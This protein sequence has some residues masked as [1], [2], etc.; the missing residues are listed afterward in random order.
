MNNLK[1]TPE[2]KEWLVALKTKIRSAQIKASLAVN[3]ALIE[4]YFDLGR[5][6]TEKDAV[7]GSRF[8]EQLSIDLKNEFP[9]MQGFSVTNLRYCRQFFNFIEN[10]LQVG[11]EIE[12]SKRPQIGAKL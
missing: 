5:M 6:I 12:N 4:F 9:D 8:L 1:I 3:S 11:G 10:Y 2:Y 7:W